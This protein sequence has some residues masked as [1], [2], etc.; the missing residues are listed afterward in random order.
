M[1]GVMRLPAPLKHAPFRAYL[2]GA[3]SGLLGMWILR[4][5]T[6]WLAWDLT[7]SAAVTGLVAF[8]N[9]APTVVSG[10]V[11]GVLAD[12]ADPR[13]GMMATQTAQA[14]VAA[15]LA[16]TVL[17]GELTLP[18]LAF[19][20]LASGVAA[21][22]YHP[23]RMTLAPRLVPPE[24]LPQAVAMTALNFNT[25]R[26]IGPA[27]GGWLI[28]VAG[29][30][31]APALAALLFAPQ[32]LMLISLPP[33]PPAPRAEG[34]DGFRRFAADLAEGARHV[35]ARAPIMEA[36]VLSGLFA[37]A[38]RG[39]LELLPAAADGLYGRGAAGLGA[40]TAAAGAGAILSSLWLGRSSPDLA[41][42]RRRARA[43]SAVGLA[44]VAALAA[45][46]LWGFAL[47]A[48]AG[49][50]AAGTVV[51]VSTQSIAQTGTPDGIR[52]RVMS[53]WILV[54]IGGAAGGALL[55][56]SLGDL[57]GLRA[58]LLIGAGGSAAALARLGRRRGVAPAE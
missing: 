5:S 41:E 29:A 15:F 8:L 40:L 30:G 9:F 54:G 46:P 51:G 12:R 14:L 45:I 13:L 58:A 27:L 56:G 35:R 43:A 31:A 2:A 20:A 25:S 50:G 47:A 16:K 37:V 4:I 23:L 53:L 42:M 36:F 7:G 44:L 33:Q 38:G 28:A 26:M 24:I 19:L 17:A 39:V 1:S 3:F 52:G 18:I 32:I 48:V 6:A 21:S 34:P 57:V 11:F 49:L 55:L 10:P 22:A